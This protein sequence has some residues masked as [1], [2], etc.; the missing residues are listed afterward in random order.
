MTRATA[1]GKI[2]LLGEH[3]VVYGRPA[4]AVPVRQVQAVAEITDEATGGPGQVWIDAPDVGL[5]AALDSLD[6]A[7]PIA[8]I[9]RL[10]I[11]DLGTARPQAMRVHLTSTIPIASGLGS[12]TAVSVAIVRALSRHLGR[13]LPADRQSA[14]AFEVERLHH[15][16]PSGIDNTVV[17]FEQPV[18]FRRGHP[19]QPFRVG[20]RFAFMIGITGQ[21][22]PTSV[23]VGQVRQQW[24]AEPERFEG[25]FDAIGR[26]VDKGREAIGGGRL[27]EVGSLMNDNQRLLKELGVSSPS[28][29]ALIEAALESGA[30]G[31]KLSGAGL[32][33]NVI[34]LVEPSTVQSVERALGA[35]GAAR[36][37]LTESVP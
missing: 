23:A 11:K 8:A 14:L 29:E 33:G 24:Q 25:L 3:A 6:A 17:A 27:G 12:G 20:G 2:I 10:T 28:L 26:L 22:S 1:L 15:G 30:R 37:I 16:T 5:S 36:T 35:A 7:Q 13:P 4:I 31:A 21:V 9:I 18:Y 34:A 19:A 32:G